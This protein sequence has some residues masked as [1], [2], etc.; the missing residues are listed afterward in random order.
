MAYTTI[1][2]GSKYFNTVLYTGDATSP[3]S[4]TGVG[5]QPD[6]T[7]VKNRSQP[8]DNGWYDIVRGVGAA[9]N[10][11]TNSATV[12]GGDGAGY[13]FVSA[14]NA[15]GISVTAG[16]VG[17]DITNKSGSNY[18]DWNWLA[19]NT[20]TSNTAGSISST[21]SVN[22][23]AG[24]SIVSYTGNGTG[25][26]T[27]GHG[28]G[29]TPTFII[30]KKRSS[31][32]NWAIYAKQ[33]NSGAGQNGG[34]YLNLTNAFSVDANFWNSTSATSSVFTV[35]A[36]GD[37]NA[38]GATFIAYC[39]SDI[40][41][42]SKF[43]SYTGNGANDGTFIYTGFKP[44]FLM[45]KR[46]D[47]GDGWLIFDDVRNTFNPEDKFLQANLN[48][49]E[50]TFSYCDFTSNGFKART[51]AASFNA[52]AGTY[53]YMAFAENPFVTSGGIPVTAR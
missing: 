29:V 20:T 47:T 34:I 35:G 7:W 8:G 37:V 24:F 27:I 36:G 13:G 28:L 30:V 3:R 21:I 15:D 49:T 2:K 11:S 52:S 53:I 17:S 16:T 48:N 12:P 22:T 25:G 45:I 42:Y 51:S 18:V 41:G 23:T 14:F 10:F 40:K 31:T 43:G 1:D 19:S 39:F 26:A 46:T 32:G 33:A 44:S 50:G 6:L 5:F 9:N 4:I 38:S